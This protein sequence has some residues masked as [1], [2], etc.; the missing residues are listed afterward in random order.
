MIKKFA[1]THYG[2][3]DVI[4]SLSHKRFV[5][6]EVAGRLKESNTVFK[7]IVESDTHE[8]E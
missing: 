8:E 5:V 1:G 2:G 7:E 3:P 4:K 6:I